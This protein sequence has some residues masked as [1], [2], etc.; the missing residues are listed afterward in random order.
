M[1]V[2]CKL[3]MVER[4][5]RKIFCWSSS[6]RFPFSRFEDSPP[7]FIAVVV[8]YS[9]LHHLLMITTIIL[10]LTSRWE[11]D[12]CWQR[13]KVASSQFFIRASSPYI[14]SAARDDKSGQLDMMEIKSVEKG[15]HSQDESEFFF[16]SGIQVENVVNRIISNSQC[17]NNDANNG[18]LSRRQGSG[19]QGDSYELSLSYQHSLVRYTSS[20]SSYYHHHLYHRIIIIIFFIINSITATNYSGQLTVS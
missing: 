5:G 8:S 20:L 7:F 17:S 14:R 3:R 9:A 4:Q 2:T 11:R 1:F 6:S 18:Q 12:S 19:S 16:K 13:S 10:M 15:E